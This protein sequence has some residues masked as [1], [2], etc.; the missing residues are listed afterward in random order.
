MKKMLTRIVLL[1]IF[2]VVFVCAG[3][4]QKD[5]DEDSLTPV[6]YKHIDEKDGSIITLTFYDN[7]KVVMN[8]YYKTQENGFKIIM[9]LDIAEGTYSG[10]P[11]KNGYIKATCTKE[12]DYKSDAASQ[13]MYIAISEAM[14]SGKSGITFTNVEFPLQTLTTPETEIWIVSND[15][16][17]L[18]MPDD[19]GSEVTFVRQ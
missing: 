12:C 8:G 15:G 16:Q 18:T 4:K 5:D 19:D 6:V 1:T 17:V 11:I 13:R 9:L 3:C 14:Q 7:E 2:A 10:N